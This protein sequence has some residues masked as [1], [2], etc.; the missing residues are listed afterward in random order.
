MQSQ[1][2]N[3]SA[4]L[5]PRLGGLGLLRWSLQN[6]RLCELASRTYAP[7][8]NQKEYALTTGIKMKT[9]MIEAIVIIRE[10]A[11]QI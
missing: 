10:S 7:A 9:L 11:N 6:H 1:S 2:S 4:V 3:V 5:I 8:A